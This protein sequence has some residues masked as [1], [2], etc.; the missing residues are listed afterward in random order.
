MSNVIHAQFGRKKPKA[1]APANDLSGAH[2]EAIAKMVEADGWGTDWNGQV[3]IF[4]EQEQEWP[5]PDSPIEFSAKGKA[6]FSELF[7][8]RFGFVRLPTTWAEINAMF[9]YCHNMYLSAGGGIGET[10][11]MSAKQA[12]IMAEQW[13]EISLEVCHPDALK[14]LRAY[15]E[16][17]ML[18]LRREHNEAFIQL[19]TSSWTADYLDEQASA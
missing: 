3:T 19:I 7:L 15:Y 6:R 16:G 17:D 9:N 2:F 14:A 10:P 18:G 4:Q 1:T 13:R 11:T 12:K 8:T 5:A